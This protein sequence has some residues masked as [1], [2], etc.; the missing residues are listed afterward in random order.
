[1]SRLAAIGVNAPQI[2]YWNGPAGDKWARL[3]DSQDRMLEAL[4]AAAMKA[5]DI[6]PGHSVLDVGCGSGTST[7]EIARRVG[8]GGQVLGIDISTPMLDVGRERLSAHEFDNVTFENKDVT[9]YPF[10]ETLFDRVFSR[11]GV[12][13]FVEPISAFTNI[14]TGLKSGGRLAFVCWQAAEKNPW[15]AVPLRVVLQNVLAP[16]P[17][18][19]EAPGPMAFSNPDRVRNILSE[20]GFSQIKIDAL[21]T[22]V[23]LEPDVSGSVQKL[24][25]V[26]PVSRLLS[27]ASD[28]VMKRVEN[29]LS[30]AIAGFQ[31]DQGVMMGSATW[32]VS[33][34]SA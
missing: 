14:R 11:F 34:I 1:M 7:I 12:M 24:L 33:A 19:S 8:D 18:D 5:C 10:R 21:E 17:A 30:D 28:D 31:T 16:P 9:I 32:I 2:E 29:D 3:A 20:A 22:L 23:P 4:G 6:R 26:G 15:I 25:E 27:G 13:F